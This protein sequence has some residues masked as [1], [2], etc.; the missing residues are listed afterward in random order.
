MYKLRNRDLTNLLLLGFLLR[1]HIIAMMI[2]IN[3]TQ[4]VIKALV[5]AAMMMINVRLASSVS[6]LAV[7]APTVGDDSTVV[8]AIGTDFV[9]DGKILGL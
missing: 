3:M 7:G 6:L 9:E 1:R 5:V 8:E 4:T 2:Q